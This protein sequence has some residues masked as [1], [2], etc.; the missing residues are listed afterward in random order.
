MAG[1][2][3][4]LRLILVR[5]PRQRCP[6]PEHHSGL[7][8]VQ[9][10][11]RQP[12]QPAPGGDHKSGGH[13]RPRHRP[14][15]EDGVQHHRT[16][17]AAAHRGADRPAAAGGPAARLRL[18]GPP[19]AVPDGV[20]GQRDR[21]PLGTEPTEPNGWCSSTQLDVRVMRGRL[22]PGHDE[23]AADS[24]RR[25]APAGPGQAAQGPCY[26]A[27]RGEERCA[28]RGGPRADGDAARRPV[29][30]L[31]LAGDIRRRRVLRLRQRAGRGAGR[32]PS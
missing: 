8:D 28:P 23:H 21:V 5:Q 9:R 30:M 24:E 15:Y 7:E 26:R 17:H 31:E 3:V 11:G 29:R 1:W 13:K 25:A 22:L 18:R 4:V 27:P 10:P 6:H 14:A 12:P 16:W 2:P 20:Q 32:R 19:P